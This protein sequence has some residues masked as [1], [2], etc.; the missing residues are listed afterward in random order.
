MIALLLTALFIAI[1]AMAA[2][3]LVMAACA[4]FNKVGGIWFWRIGSYGGSF[5]HS[6]KTSYSELERQDREDYGHAV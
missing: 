3:A 2:L 6:A 1:F 5:Y 4:S